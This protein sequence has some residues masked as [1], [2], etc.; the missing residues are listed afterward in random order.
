[1]VVI[2]ALLVMKTRP[3]LTVQHEPMLLSVARGVSHA[4]ARPRVA[5]VLVFSFLV[6]TLGFPIISTLAPYWMQH[7]LGLGPVGWTF[8]GWIWGLGTVASTVYLSTHD[9]RE[10]LGSLVLVSAGGFG[11]TLVVFGLTR[12]L[13][14]SAAMWCLNGTFFTA[15]MISSTSL[16]QVLVENEYMGRV[17]SLRQVSG[18]LNQI[19]SAPLGALG[20]AYGMG[21]MVPGV[22]GLL[23]A[24][25]VLIPLLVRGARDLQPPEERTGTGA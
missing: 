1:V 18:A 2:A 23:V 20:D 8:M 22:A 25:V 14:L 12:S 7:E 10:R 19:A 15:N 6:G 16:L 9:V 11:L 13:P 3:H 4:A 24:L 17:M 5:W 21:R